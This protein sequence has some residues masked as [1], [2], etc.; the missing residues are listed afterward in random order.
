MI[1]YSQKM[2]SLALTTWI[3]LLVNWSVMSWGLN[4]SPL[5][6]SLFGKRLKDIEE[7]TRNELKASRAL[8]DNLGDC[9][10][11]VF[12]GAGGP[13]QFTD[14]LKATIGDSCVIWDW[15]EHRGSIAT[16]AFDGE[17]VG[18]TLADAF[19]DRQ[20]VHVIGISVGGFCANSMAT[21]LYNRVP[22]PLVRLTL[23]DPFCSRGLL[24]IGY[25]AKHFGVNA[26]YAEHFLNTDDPVP[27]TNEPLPN[28][29]CVD[30]TQA[31]ERKIFELP[32]GESMHCWPVAY[33]ARVGYRKET[34]EHGASNARGL[35][36]RII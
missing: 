5:E 1:S 4:L 10:A 17:A 35:V 30:V 8:L 6:S 22:K 33:Y 19:V 32:E 20:E 2:A 27:S 29:Y 14:E 25:G 36:S 11:I 12:P 21:S 26:D 28:C 7:A 16:A 15:Q 13:D 3:L 9:P 31:P 24:G 23:L 34:L 18:E